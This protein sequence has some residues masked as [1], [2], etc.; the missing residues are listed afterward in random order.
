MRDR[1][2]KWSVIGF[3]SDN[4]PHPKVKRGDLLVATKHDTDGSKDVTVLAWKARMER[5][6]VAYVKVTNLK[7][8]QTETIYPRKIRRGRAKTL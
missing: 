3:A 7:T 1:D 4:H 5:G 2:W 6:D 8:Y